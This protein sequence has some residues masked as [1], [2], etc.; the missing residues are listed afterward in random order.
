MA[1]KTWKAQL[2]RNGVSYDIPNLI[3]ARVER[4][5]NARDNLLELR[6]GTRGGTNIYGGN[7]VYFSGDIIKFWATEGNVDTTN[8]N[9]LMGTYIVKDV[10]ADPNSRQITIKCG[11]K[12]YNMLAKIYFGVIDP[13]LPINQIIA[14]VVQ[15]VNKNGTSRTPVGSYIASTRSNGSAFPST[16]YSSNGKSAYEVIAELSQTD[17]T[18]DNFPY[19]YYF[20]EQDQ[21]YWFYPTA[22]P[23]STVLEFG[24]NPNILS[25]KTSK[26]DAE[27]ISFVVYNAGLDKNGAAIVSYYKDP[28]KSTMDNRMKNQPMTDIAKSLKKQLTDAGTYASTTNAD[29]ITECKKRA[30]ARAQAIIQQVGQGLWNAAIDMRGV[31]YSPGQLYTCSAPDYGFPS[32]RLRLMEVAHDFDKNGWQTKLKLEQDPYSAQKL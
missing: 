28:P 32:T 19:V 20:D 1:F 13:A 3:S 14:R 26:K 2:V 12:T 10:F 5:L 9:H 6:L 30:G 11:D 25:M 27:V 4:K 22:A 24:V 31:R 15:D 7:V 29:F 17:Y 21:F 16:T 18:G 23:E 8:L